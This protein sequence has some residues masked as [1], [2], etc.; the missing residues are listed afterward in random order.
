MNVVPIQYTRGVDLVS[1]KQVQTTTYSDVG[2]RRLHQRH[3]RKRFH[4]WLS[5]MLYNGDR[6]FLEPLT[7]C[8]YLLI[9]VWKIMFHHFYA[10]DKRWNVFR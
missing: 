2:S 7:W 1:N 10:L 9:S 3:L 5:K 8:V 6:I 4:W